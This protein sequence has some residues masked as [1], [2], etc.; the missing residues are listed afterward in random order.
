MIKEIWY[1]DIC[2]KEYSSKQIPFINK[3]YRIEF[4]NMEENRRYV[5]DLCRNCQKNLV[6]YLRDNIKQEDE[7]D[8]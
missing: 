5:V 4:A 8:D 2:G 3:K 6:Q 7:G 1:C